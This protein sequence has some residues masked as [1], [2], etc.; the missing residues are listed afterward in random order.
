MSVGEHDELRETAD[1]IV[2]RPE[3]REEQPTLVERALD[4]VFEELGDIVGRVVGGGGGYL[5]GYAILAVAL[6]L[7]AYFV[8]RFFP[9]RRLLARSD[10]YEIEREITVRRSRDE[11]LELAVEAESSGDWDVAV[12][13]R[14]HA[15]TAG[16]AD[17]ERLPSTLS[18][19]S[20]EHRRAF[21]AAAA[22]GSE[23]GHGGVLPID[24]FNSVTDRYEQVW[25]GGD[26]ADQPDS[27][28]LA[29]ADRALLDGD[30]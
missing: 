18:T 11:W 16:L 14:Y 3:F 23:V 17:D 8:W 22:A 19:T 4:R 15:L 6:G 28:D 30:R 27:R 12:H 29:D 13:A 26:P 25:F 7:A 21:A 20:G 9:R 1:E 24:V 5:V 10:G 2:S